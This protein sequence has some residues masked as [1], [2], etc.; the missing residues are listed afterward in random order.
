MQDFVTV[1]LNEWDRVNVLL[2]QSNGTIQSQRR[3]PIDSVRSVTLGDVNGDAVLDIVTA[4]V[5]SISIVLGRGN[6]R[7]HPEQQY[8]L[9]STPS[10]IAL[11]DINSDT[12]VDIVASYTAHCAGTFACEI[13]VP[14]GLSILLGRRD[15][16]FEAEQQIV[17][18]VEHPDA[19]RDDVGRVLLGD[20][21]RRQCP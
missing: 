2:R 3:V 18:S 11:E 1:S 5:Q 10:S 21:K 14:G 20:V 9:R 15:G 13:Q 7:F 12:I 17:S 19:L 16:T 8:P 4:N 6:G